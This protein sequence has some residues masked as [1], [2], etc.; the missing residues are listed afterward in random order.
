MGKK[1]KLTPIAMVRPSEDF[2]QAPSKIRP[3]VE[4]SQEEFNKI[5]DQ[6]KGLLVSLDPDGVSNPQNI[7][8]YTLPVGSKG[9]VERYIVKAK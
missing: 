7:T 4:I 6:G 9:L 5:A 1:V 2:I 8:T 3:G